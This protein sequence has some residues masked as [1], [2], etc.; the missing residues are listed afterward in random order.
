MNKIH[1]LI[2]MI[3][4]LGLGSAAI[5]PGLAQ[6][7]MFATS[8]ATDAERCGDP[9]TSDSS[10]INFNDDED[11]HDNSDNYVNPSGVLQGNTSGTD[12]MTFSPENIPTVD[13][14]GKGADGRSIIFD[15]DNDN[16]S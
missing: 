3:L 16:L 1:Y 7:V 14:T 10:N 4:G 5:L 15:E 9:D 8:C 12:N 11:R 2:P 13:V 6:Q